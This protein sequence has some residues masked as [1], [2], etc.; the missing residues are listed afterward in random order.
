M[1]EVTHPR[2][3]PGFRRA[4][5]IVFVLLLPVAAHAL[6]DY[7]E[8]RRLSNAV[9]AIRQ[10]GERLHF[11]KSGEGRPI[12]AEQKQAS[13]Y[14]GA[15]AHLVRD[16]YGKALAA[17][18]QDIAALS[19]L[20]PAA[21]R[22]DPRLETLR[23]ASEQYAPAL[24]LL[25]RAARL[26]A[27]GLD[28][29]DDSRYGFPN[30]SLADVNALRIA[31]LAFLGEPAPASQALLGTLRIPRAY[32][33]V[34]WLN[35][36]DTDRTLRL[37]LA[38][39]PPAEP[40]LRAL[41]DEYEKW[42]VDSEV[43]DRLVDMRARL[44][45]AVWPGAFGAL[46][47][48]PRISDPQDRGRSPRLIDITLRPWVTRGIRR[49][50]LQYE[51]ALAAARQPWPA[52]L[53]SARGMAE[54]YPVPPFGADGPRGPVGFISSFRA[55]LAANPSAGELGRLAPAIGTQIA[56]RRVAITALSVERYRRAHDG[57][58][59]ES[60]SGLV[61][62]YSGA[63]ARRSLQRAVSSVRPRTW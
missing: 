5:I 18:D 49:M 8:A 37:L 6:W 61:P 60:L 47:T 57:I 35:P 53:D 13:R 29:G 2:V 52:K 23:L 34:Y 46:P 36:V 14:Y 25:D 55:V 27:R 48:L 28:Y 62:A 31:R 32:R 51:E 7:I 58:A 1:T 20:E 33:D 21:A 26:D 50:L 22:K 56:K 11:G 3:R 59:P 43:E 12:T 4:A 40:E 63:P 17:A 15:A 16:A 10:R 54:R 45:E 44:I 38:F 9:E 39:A 42:D 30:K 24:D 41:Q 19:A